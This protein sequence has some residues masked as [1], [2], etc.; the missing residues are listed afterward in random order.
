M[1][2]TLSDKRA[3]WIHRLPPS[4]NIT[5]EQTV[6]DLTPGQW[7]HVE[8][9]VLQNDYGIPNGR[10]TFWQ[11]GQLIFDLQDVETRHDPEDFGFP[12]SGG[13][14]SRNVVAPANVYGRGLRNTDDGSFEIHT[15]FDNVAVTTERVGP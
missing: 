10:I 15:L 7:H 6:A 1:Y 4:G 3:E 13:G 11:D 5:H 2:F 9:Y 8:G 12:V 14:S